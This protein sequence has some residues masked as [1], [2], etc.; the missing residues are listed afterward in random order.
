MCLQHICIVAGNNL[1]LEIG[2]VV[3]LLIY[4]TGSVMETKQRNGERTLSGASVIGDKFENVM[5]TCTQT[6]AHMQY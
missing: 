2:F 1:K 5:N 3:A 4:C 6:Y